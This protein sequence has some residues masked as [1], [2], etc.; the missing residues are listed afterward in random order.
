MLRFLSTAKYH[1]RNE[2]LVFVDMKN[3]GKAVISCMCMLEYLEASHMI[4]FLSF[5]TPS[6]V[7]IKSQHLPSHTHGLIFGTWTNEGFPDRAFIAWAFFT[8]QTGLVG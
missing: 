7:S 5:N 1:F 2:L 8:L 6:L 3:N 4:N